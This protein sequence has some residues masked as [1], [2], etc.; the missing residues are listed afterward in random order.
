[1][2]K[3]ER[4][5]RLEKAYKPHILSKFRFITHFPVDADDERDGTHLDI[6]HQGSP[7][8]E[9]VVFAATREGYCKQR[10]LLRRS[11]TLLDG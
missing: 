7:I 3:L 6:A 10:E 1:M 11:F 2:T 4:I 9:L 8:G 5:R